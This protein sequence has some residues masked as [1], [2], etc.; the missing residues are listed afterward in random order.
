LDTPLS[1]R[2]SGRGAIKGH[3]LALCLLIAELGQ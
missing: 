2:F 1:P 3:K